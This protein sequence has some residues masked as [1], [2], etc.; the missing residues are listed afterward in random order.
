MG[1]EVSDFLRP[2]FWA[3]NIHPEDVPRVM[4]GRA[5][6]LKQGRLYHE[7]RFRHQ[8]GSW[9][10]MSDEMKVIND[11][12]G[13]PEKVFGYWRDITDRRPVGGTAAR[14]L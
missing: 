3:G 6:L 1:C 10:W 2:G 14:T 12:N 7:Y 11:W 5:Q 9:R 4:A 8:D 13:Q